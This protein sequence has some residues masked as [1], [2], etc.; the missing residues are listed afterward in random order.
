MQWLDHGLSIEIFPPKEFNF[1]ECL[2]FLG[3]SEQEILH[4]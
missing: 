1:N 4:Q 2:V 3:R